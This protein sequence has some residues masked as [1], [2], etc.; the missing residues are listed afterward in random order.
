[1]DLLPANMGYKTVLGVIIAIV[2]ALTD[3]QVLS[4]L[5]ASWAH[6]LTVIGAAIAVLG[7]R[8]AQAKVLTALA[9][10]PAPTAGNAPSGN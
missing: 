9:P 4:L 3:P 7:L 1:M 8:H 6:V 5:P 2:G 10:T